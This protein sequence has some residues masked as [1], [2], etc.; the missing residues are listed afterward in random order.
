MATVNIEALR[1]VVN[2]KSLQNLAYGAALSKMSKIKRETLKDFNEHPVTVEIEGGENAKSTALPDGNL[3]SFIGFTQGD[4][5][6]EPV[7]QALE[8]N[9]SVKNK[10][11]IK[12]NQNLYRFEFEASVPNLKDLESAAPMPDR[13]SSD[14]WISSIEKGISGLQNYIFGIYRTSF[15]TTGLQVKGKIRSE[16]YRPRKYISAILKTLESKL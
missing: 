1:K 14:S 5:P 2:A 16:N 13:W 15:S 4:T 3:F 10:A 6:I 8:D 11:V 9:I 12:Q 7:R